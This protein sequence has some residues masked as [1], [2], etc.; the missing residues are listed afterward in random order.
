MTSKLGNIFFITVIAFVALAGC[1]RARD[2][3]GDTMPPADTMIDDV[4]TDTVEAV[5][6][7]LVWLIDYPENGKD[8][9]LQWVAS[10]APTLQAPEEVNRIRSYDSLENVG[11]RRFVEFEFDSFLDAATYLNRPEIA[12]ILEE[13]PN[14]AT[15]VS[16]HTF[17]ERSHYAKTEKKDWPIKGIMFVEYL[18]G[19]KAAYLQWVASISAHIEPPQLKAIAAYDNY[20]GESPHRLVTVEFANEE[21]V[22]AYRELEEIMAIEAEIDVR[23][24][25]RVIYIFQLRSD[26]INE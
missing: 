11:P 10:N 19:G 8:A 23:A 16:A 13:L 21:D 14:R 22:T 12:A 3:V 20:Y 7:K 24:A 18:L 5:P 25:S 26:Y 4:M 15:Q 9:Y 17:I 6:V 2:M 1:E